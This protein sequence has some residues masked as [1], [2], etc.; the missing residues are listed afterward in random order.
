MSHNHSHSEGG[1]HAGHSHSVTAAQAGSKAFLIGIV[2]NLIYVIA[3]AG[4]GLW[5]NSLALLTDA[6][7]NLSDVASLIISLFAFRLARMK[8]TDTFTYGYKKSTILAALVNAVVLLI[9]IGIIG[10]ETFQR[11]GHPRPLEGGIIAWVAGIGIVINGISA[12]LFFRN[13]EELNSRSAYMHLL[14][15][16]LVSAGVVVAGIIISYTHWYWLDT[17][18]SA[19]V[20]IVILIGTWSLLTDS[21]RLTLDAVPRNVN[22]EKV[23]QSIEKVTGVIS[24]SHV[25]VW[26]MSTAEN[27]LTAHVTLSVSD[28][29][30]HEIVA[31]IKHELQHQNI[32]H[33]TIETSLDSDPKGG[34]TCE[35][36][37]H[38]HH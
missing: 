27:A 24:V 35:I 6:G 25:H 21:L 23:T 12:M 4:A 37:R 34:G 1:A 14:A 9:A 2:L 18:V 32:Q 3:E 31:N 10:Y 38:T 36:N 26:A 17:A 29:E 16:A 13:R 7:H 8:P 28:Q 33:A 20:L 11:I 19:I 22:M 30:Q 15:D 5:T